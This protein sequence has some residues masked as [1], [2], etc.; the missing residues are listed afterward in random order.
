M[1]DDDL[2]ARLFSDE[3]PGK[4]ERTTGPIER[5]PEAWDAAPVV[6][7]LYGQAV[8]LFTIGQLAS[9]LGLKPVTLRSWEDKGWMPK[10]PI[11]T[12]PPNW[13]G[14][15]NKNIKGRRLWTRSMV[16]GIVRIAHE[17][18]VLLPRPQHRQVRHTNF[19]QRVVA[20]Y[21][22]TMREL[23]ES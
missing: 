14:L 18:G 13:A 12:R 21:E 9:A 6:K 2:F 3:L 22:E 5:E 11:R 20:L 10:T 23:K 7:T 17:E 15:P 8:E 19:T 1:S 16:T 4:R